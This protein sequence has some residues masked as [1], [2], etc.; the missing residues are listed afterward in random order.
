MEERADRLP[1]WDTRTQPKPRGYLLLDFKGTEAHRIKTRPSWAA[2]MIKPGRNV[3]NANLHELALVE[4]A[5]YKALF[6]AGKI[7]IV[8]D[9]FQ[10]LADV[11]KANESKGSALQ[12]ENAEL[13]GKVA[14][15]EMQ[16]AAVLERLAGTDAPK[17]G[18]K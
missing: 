11:V 8:D 13:R 9:S 4:D 7:A 6:E 12:A 10:P 5:D 18:G 3:I 14:D 2:R 15:L 16:M 1:P 17:K